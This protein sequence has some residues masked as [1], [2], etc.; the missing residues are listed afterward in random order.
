MRPRNRQRPA[1]AAGRIALDGHWSSD[2]FLSAALGI[3]ISKAVVHF[4]RERKAA[5]ALRQARGLAP[6]R[7][8]RRHAFVLSTRSIAWSYSF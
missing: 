6:E 1:T 3:G 4:N 7:D 5:R 8:Q 2:V